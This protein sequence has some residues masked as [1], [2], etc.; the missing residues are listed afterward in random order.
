MQSK[1][2]KI[3]GYV[4]LIVLFQLIPVFSSPHFDYSFN[5]FSVHPFVR[6]F[7]GYSCIILFYFVHSY[8]LLPRFYEKKRAY[9][10]LLTIAYFVGMT[11]A[12]HFLLSNDNL[13][14]LS[15]ENRPQPVGAMEERTDPPS[16]FFE[17]AVLF[18]PFCLI[19]IVSFAL[20][21]SRKARQVEL[22]KAQT[23]LQ[24][25]RY[26]LQPH[27]LFNSLNNIYSVSVIAPDK[28]PKYILELSAILRYLLVTE[29]EKMVDLKQ[30]VLF[31]EQ[32]VSLQQLRYGKMAHEWQISWPDAEQ[33]EGYKIPPFLIIPLI[34][35]VF[36]YGIHPEKKSPV[37]I[38]LTIK[39]GQ[40]ILQTFN[41][42]N[43]RANEALLASQKLGLKKTQ[44]LIQLLYPSKHQ[45]LVDESEIG[46]TLTLMIML[47]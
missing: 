21:I 13:G 22:E 10:F 1:W 25:L 23:E 12:L 6:N 19:T 2:K 44:E 40:L 9:Y 17:Y 16:A 26:Q 27:F 15:S 36:K 47:K 24:N 33:L 42:K 8:W 20:H 3:G 37:S 7:A 45:L 30:D 43:N 38:A 39:Q 46:F 34:E 5:M 18:V 11:L 32:F 31:C 4:V 35:N 14:L 29:K 41:Y 28:T